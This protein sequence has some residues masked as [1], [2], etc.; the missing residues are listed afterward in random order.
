MQPP[1][2]ITLVTP[3]YKTPMYFLERLM[4]GI[5]RAKHDVEWILVDDSPNS[6]EVKEFSRRAGQVLPNFQLISHAENSGI[7][8]SYIS[9]FKNA[10]G[11]FVGILD[12]DDEIEAEK[13]ISIIKLTNYNEYD[14]L[15][16]NEAKFNHLIKEEYIKP[17]FDIL[18][19]LYYFYPHH[20]TFFKSDLTRD[21]IRSSSLLRK[22]ST[23]FDIALWYEYLGAIVKNGA[24]SL[25]LPY[26]TYG[27]RVHE[28]STASSIDQ[29]PTNLIERRALAEEFLNRYEDNTLAIFNRTDVPFVISGQFGLD[30]EN[31]YEYADQYFDVQ[32][33]TVKNNCVTITKVSEVYSSLRSIVRQ[34]PL[35][36]LSNTDLAD[37]IYIS[38][39]SHVGYESGHI[40][41]VP[42]LRSVK[43]LPDGPY[44]RFR[45]KRM[46]SLP[47]GGVRRFEI[48]VAGER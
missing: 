16:T 44:L 25:H 12:H 31:V 1:V 9:G 28:D 42:F 23:A 47:S 7:R 22:S 15:Y 39:H 19:A 30:Y 4:I 48:L 43:T 27:W 33:C 10:R 29:K 8:E 24:R 35:G 5:S 20:I 37:E 18:S 17:S 32:W 14:I 45:S 21:I 40:C 38:G 26:T 6:D 41:N 11:T 2:P 46:T 3:C 34:I 13:L 36:Y